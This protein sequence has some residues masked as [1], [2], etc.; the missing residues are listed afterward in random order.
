MLYRLIALN[1]CVYI[2]VSFLAVSF[3][4]QHL[5]YAER[6]KDLFGLATTASLSELVG[7]RFAKNEL[8]GRRS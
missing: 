8:V 3:K 5:E 4:I 7:R 1:V 2:L 6:V